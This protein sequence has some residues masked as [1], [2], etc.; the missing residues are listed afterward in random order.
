MKKKKEKKGA[1]C[2]GQRYYIYI[3]KSFLCVGLIDENGDF[4]FG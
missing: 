2:V 1:G 4:G 3:K